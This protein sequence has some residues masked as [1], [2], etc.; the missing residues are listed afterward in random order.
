MAYGLEDLL[1]Q[2]KVLH[3]G[4]WYV[5]IL[6]RNFVVRVLD[7]PFDEYAPGLIADSIQDTYIYM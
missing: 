3:G 7:I 4:G 5:H 2:K 1:D 6:L